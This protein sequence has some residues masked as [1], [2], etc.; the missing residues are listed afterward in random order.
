MEMPVHK[1]LNKSTRLIVCRSLMGVSHYSLLILHCQLLLQ[2][3]VFSWEGP[4]KGD[5]FIKVMVKC[6]S[7]M[8]M[9]WSSKSLKML[10]NIFLL[11][12][13]SQILCSSTYKLTMTNMA[14]WHLYEHLD[15][16]VTKQAHTDQTGTY[17][18]LM[19]NRT[20]KIHIFKY[21]IKQL[22]IL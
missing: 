22:K 16:Q 18:R 1:R 13:S 15:K 6:I 19:A 2:T 8:A 11:V 5:S 7:K 20:A 4:A 17:R 21:I 12:V 3:Q 9:Q 10:L 14:N